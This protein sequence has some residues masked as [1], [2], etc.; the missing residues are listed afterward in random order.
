MWIDKKLENVDI[1]VNF[2]FVSGV[3][4]SVLSCFLQEVHAIMIPDLR[5]QQLF[6]ICQV[7]WSNDN[8]IAENDSCK[9]YIMIEINGV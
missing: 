4:F 1:D 3:C 2:L 6:Y 8:L 9:S 5:N 7:F